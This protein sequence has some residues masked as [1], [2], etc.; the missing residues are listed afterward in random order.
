MASPSNPRKRTK[1]AGSA[2]R[3][4]DTRGHLEG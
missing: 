3:N 1:E 2:G 4:I